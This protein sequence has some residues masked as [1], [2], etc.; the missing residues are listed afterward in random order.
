MLEVAPNTK[1]V[2]GG[3]TILD[4]LR[5]MR[6]YQWS[7][8]FL[9]FA[10]VFLSHTIFQGP[11]FLHAAEAFLAFSTAASALYIVNDLLDL[12]ADRQHPRKRFR[13]FAQG[14]LGIGQGKLMAAI[15]FFLAAAIS[16]LMP[17]QA[18]MGIALY[19]FTGLFYSFYLKRLLFVDVI[20]LAGLYTL[21]LLVGGLATAVTISPW[22]LAFSIFVFTSLAICK[23]LSELRACDLQQN[24]LLP[25]RA[26]SQNDLVSLT[27]LS[28]S[29]GYA[30]VVVLALYFNSPEVMVLYQHP[31][32]MWL[33][34][35][36]LTYWIS[37]A[38]VIANRGEMHHDPIVF[39]FGDLASWVAGLLTLAIVVGAL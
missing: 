2:R 32:V 34:L 25:A 17:L 8:N 13:P 28:S 10:P 22:T 38:I 24:P 4:A 39:A 30:A 20:T 12:E 14:R 33:L 11:R 37:R 9:V 35:P 26:Y 7:K 16:L 5:A 19:V 21:R 36:L 6:V 31:R 18:G 3:G 29:S 23:R 15:L 27:S 1:E